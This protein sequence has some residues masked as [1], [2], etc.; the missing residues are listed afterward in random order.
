M[1]WVEPGLDSLSPFPGKLAGQRSA[2]GSGGHGV[3]AWVLL[4][5]G[6][7]GRGADAACTE[8]RIINLIN[9]AAGVPSFVPGE[10]VE[11]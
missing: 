1:S 3:G 9:R 11:R 7:G 4:V 6:G 5:C 2:S 8:R 10:G